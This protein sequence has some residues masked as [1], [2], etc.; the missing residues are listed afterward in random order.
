L[1]FD[2]R[3]LRLVVLDWEGDQELWSLTYRKMICMA[4]DST[5][6]GGWVETAARITIDAE[7]EKKIN[8]Y[9]GNEGNDPPSH[10]EVLQYIINHDLVPEEGLGRPYATL[11]WHIGDITDSWDLTD[12]QAHDFLARNE[13][14]IR[15]PLTQWGNESVL[16]TLLQEEGIKPR[17]D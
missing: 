17:E 9:F 11:S 8:A 2:E 3:Q 4:D 14:Y 16:P 7:M 13:K 15:D 5:L 10:D 12:E 6:S 1:W